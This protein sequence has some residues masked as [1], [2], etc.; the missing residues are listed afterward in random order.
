MKHVLVE[1]VGAGQADTGV[2]HA[3]DTCVVVTAP[4]LGDDIQAIKAGILE[5]GDIFV[6]N[7][8]DRDGADDAAAALQGMVDLM[9]PKDRKSGWQ[10]PVLKVSA[11]DCS[12]IDKLLAALAE[13]RTYLDCS[14]L[15]CRKAAAR[16]RAAVE[17]IVEKKIAKLIFYELKD[18]TDYDTLLADVTS[19]KVDPYT[20]AESI[21]KKMLEV[22]MGKVG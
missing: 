16:A 7:K 5:I 13:H 11:R 4:G 15:L 3:A 18:K 19:R 6:V 12:G 17:E 1:T 21:L 8:S 14:S 10:Y 22:K 2:M 9:E 20:A